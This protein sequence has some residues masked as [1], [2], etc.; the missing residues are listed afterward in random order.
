MTGVTYQSDV[1]DQQWSHHVCF[2]L[3]HAYLCVCLPLAWSDRPPTLCCYV[4]CCS[5]HHQNGTRWQ[6]RLK[7]SST[8]C[9]QLTL[10]SVF[11][12][13][14]HSSIRGL[15]Y[16]IIT[17]S[18]QWSLHLMFNMWRRSLS[19]LTTDDPIFMAAWLL[20]WPASHCYLQLMFLSRSFYSYFSLFFAT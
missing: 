15:V 17:H 7:R 10:Q 5:I 20:C 12:L 6:W 8:T 14:R 3:S 4:V 13:L 1:I 11:Q 19:V 18:D 16:A 2:H 9:W